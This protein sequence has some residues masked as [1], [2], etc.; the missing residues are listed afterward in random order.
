[1]ASM[2]VRVLMYEV[3]DL[4][5]GQR[6]FS[7]DGTLWFPLCYFQEETGRVGGSWGQIAGHTECV[8]L[9]RNRQGLDRRAIVACC[10][11]PLSTP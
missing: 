11:K 10:W 8:R 3:H 2:L 5:M 7:R 9:H 1:M 6:I 4:F